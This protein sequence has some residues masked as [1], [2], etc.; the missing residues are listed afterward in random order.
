MD[1]SMGSDF[2][3]GKIGVVTVLF[4]SELVLPEFFTSITAQTYRNFTVFTIDNAS[5]DASTTI[6]QRHP[7]LCSLIVN[8]DNRGVAAANNQGIA[9]ALDSGCEFVL[10]LNN[11]VCFGSELFAQLV[12]GLRSHSCNMV[13]P[14]IF[15]YD[16]PE[17]IWCAGGTFK[18]WMGERPSHL[19]K[20]QRITSLSPRSRQVDFTPTCCV[21]IHKA[22]FA[23]IG[24]MD[25]RYFVYWDD[26]DFMLRARRAGLKL[27]LLPNARLWHKVSALTGSRSEFTLYYATRNH[28]YYLR[29]HLP[30]LLSMAWCL[31]Y[32][33]VYLARAPFSRRSRIQLQAL[34]A[35]ARI[36]LH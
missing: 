32:C 25:E 28:A 8:N 29:K 21:L 15:Y 4:N 14:A 5:Q 11:D 1:Y 27:L 2:V 33:A 3:P 30:F 9:A 17:I 22:V 12:D 6:C 35:G 16:A 13:T 10:L 23:R 34:I 31:I 20:D 36:P 19:H 18:R 7:E 24:L 26:T